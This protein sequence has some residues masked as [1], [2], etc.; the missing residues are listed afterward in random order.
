MAGQSSQTHVT[1][2]I[3]AIATPPGV[4]G[5][6]VI[7]VSGPLCAA[8][9]KQ[10]LGRPMPARK[11]QFARFK[12][13]DGETIDSGIA[14]MFEA[15]A[16]FTGED[17]LELQGHG[18]PQI[19]QMLM[20]R[21][22]G[23]GARAARPG[24]FSERAFLNNK[25]DLVQAEAI[26]DLIESGTEASARAAQRSLDGLFSDQ[27]NGLQKELIDL[28]VF[29]EA[30]M[31]FPDEEIDFLADSDVLEQLAGVDDRLHDLQEQAQQGQL[32]RDGIHIAIAGLPNAGKSSLLNALAGRES[33]IVTAI[34][35]TTRD[36]LREHISLDGLPV[37]VSDT[38]GIRDSDC[39]V[40]AEG[41][42]RARATFSAADLVLLVIDSS[43]PVEP[44]MA[45]RAELPDNI[46]CIVVNNKI[47]LTAGKAGPDDKP[48]TVGVSAKTGQGL[49]DLV[50]LV[51]NTVG[52][53]VSQEGVFSARTRHLDAL[54][55]TR[56]HVGAGALQ[57]EQFNAPEILAEE[58]RLAQ[59]SLGEITGQF[60]PDDLLG[61][62]FSS[63]CIGK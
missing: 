33:A 61:A 43:Q 12:D 11:A 7:R 37:H 46:P 48:L 21:I 19:M 42:R 16:S 47:D 3:C 57:L 1:E 26:A 41:V 44:Q 62:I 45:L 55:R 49:R 24:E 10:V 58:L 2:T 50:D 60:L 27:V 51:K 9:A 14:I 30:A 38:A 17:V 63:F 29:V 22:M 23:L 31:D 18:G 35:G 8:I 25:L 36:V 40:E 52:A 15:P 54:R 13:A 4:G 32:L 20:A 28:R 34:P 53:A 59:K 56:D 5:V 6:G 39:L